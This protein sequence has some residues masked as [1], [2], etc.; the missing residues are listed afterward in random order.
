MAYVKRELHRFTAVGKEYGCLLPDYYQTIGPVCGIT[1]VPD[2]D[3]SPP[4]P[5]PV[6]ELI[7]LGLLQRVRATYLEGTTRKSAQIVCSRDKGD[8]VIGGL[9]NKTLRTGETI[10]SACFPRRRRLG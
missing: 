4:N 2:N 3:P 7:R 8:T 1:R 9:R 5:T 10:T 6:P